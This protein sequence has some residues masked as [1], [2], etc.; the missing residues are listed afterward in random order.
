MAAR[1]ADGFVC[2]EGFRSCRLRE[3]YADHD[4]SG[5]MHVLACARC[6]Q[7]ADHRVVEAKRG[8]PKPEA[9]T[10]VVRKRSGLAR[11]TA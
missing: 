8:R 7:V 11:E 2:S 5:S 4:S 3:Y 6:S 9:E 10:E 1:N